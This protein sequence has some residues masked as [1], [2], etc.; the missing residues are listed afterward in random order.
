MPSLNK[1][2]LPGK[3]GLRATVTGLS[4]ESTPP[5]LAPSSNIAKPAGSNKS[6]RKTYQLTAKVCSFLC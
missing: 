6:P 2:L 3:P 5:M 4:P 1:A